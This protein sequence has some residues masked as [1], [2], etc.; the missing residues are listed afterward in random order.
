MKM[1]LID[2]N[3]EWEIMEVKQARN[4]RDDERVPY[5]VFVAGIGDRRKVVEDG[6]GAVFRSDPLVTLSEIV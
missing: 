3:R 6:G 2:L 5:H 4:G 1:K